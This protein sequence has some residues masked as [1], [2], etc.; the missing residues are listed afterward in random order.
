[1]LMLWLDFDTFGGPGEDHGGHGG[2]G[3]GLALVELDDV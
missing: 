3:I 1:M 2:V